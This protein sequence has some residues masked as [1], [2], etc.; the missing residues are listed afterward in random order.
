MTNSKGALN[1]LESRC[2]SDLGCAMGSNDDPRLAEIVNMWDGLSEETR[3]AIHATA[4]AACDWR[5][6]LVAV[7]RQR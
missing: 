3:A 1:P 7:D 5:R 2:S 4:N 6:P